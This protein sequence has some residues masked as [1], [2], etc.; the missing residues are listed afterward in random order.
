MRLIFWIA[1]K[2][3]WPKGRKFFDVNTTVALLGICLGVASL[4]VSMAVIA[5]FESTMKMALADMTG[6]LQ[7]VK[8]Q[9]DPLAEVIEK[10][11]KAEPDAVGFTSFSQ[12]EGVLAHQGT[13]SGIVIR[14]I[15]SATMDQVVNLK[16]RLLDGSEN[17]QVEALP[18]EVLIG[19]GLAKNYSLKVGDRFR[20]VIPL[21]H[22][23][24]PTQFRRKMTEFQVKGVM[25]FGRNKFNERFI[26]SDLSV[27][28]EM[29]SQTEP[30]G[31]LVKLKDIDKARTSGYKIS[32]ILGPPYR[33]SDWKDVEDNLFAA[34]EFERRVVFFVVFIIIIAAAFV[35]AVSLYIHVI[36]K[37]SDIG[38][39]KAIGLSRQK[40]I[41]VFSLQGLILGVL[42]SIAGL[43]LGAVFC[44]AFVQ[45]E[46]RFGI[47]PGSVYKLDQIQL[48]LRLMDLLGI[49]GATL[50][51][52]VLA[53]LAPALKGANLS[54]VEGLRNE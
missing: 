12:V 47:L 41:K 34:I 5:G 3:L 46:S 25:D 1:L 31:L 7:I 4:T 33:V 18:A 22:E 50:G 13:V 2:T 26:I 40:L 17:L 19:R 30:M 35:V 45:L 51:I 44:W 20:V 43:F 29:K 48:N 14:G 24:D 11:K 37:F 9:Q 28:K 52:C 38:L 10:I 16:S 36:R 15:D 39:L 6:H 53:S 8:P 21:P 23:I 42:G 54:A 49:L 32:E 27:V